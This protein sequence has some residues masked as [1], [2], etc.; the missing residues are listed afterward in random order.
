[1]SMQPWWNDIDRG[2]P[3]NLDKNVFQCH[4]VHYKWAEP[5]VNLGLCGEAGD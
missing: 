1:M 5:G 3:N 2:K 4:T